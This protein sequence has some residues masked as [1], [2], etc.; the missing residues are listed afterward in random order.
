M[1]KTAKL[2]RTNTLEGRSVAFPR[3]TRLPALLNAQQLGVSG[4]VDR[5]VLG[6]RLAELLG[7]LGHVENVVDHLGRVGWLG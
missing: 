2:A 4:L 5:Q 6:R 7:R 1:C 3:V